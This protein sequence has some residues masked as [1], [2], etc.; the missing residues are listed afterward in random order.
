MLTALNSIVRF[1]ASGQRLTA[2]RTEFRRFCLILRGVAAGR[3]AHRLRSRSPAPA[4]FTEI[5]RLILGAAGRANPLAAWLR[6]RQRVRKLVFG[7]DLLHH[8]V[9]VPNTEPFVAAHQYIRELVHFLLVCAIEVGEASVRTVS[10]TQFKLDLVKPRGIHVDGDIELIVAFVAA[11]LVAFLVAIRVLIEDF[12]LVFPDDPETL[13]N[14][15]E[16]AAQ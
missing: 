10:V 7:A 2:L 6:N 11:R 13:I 5:I 9:A 15:F 12:F 4:V 8:S 1:M 14:P 3:T 16:V